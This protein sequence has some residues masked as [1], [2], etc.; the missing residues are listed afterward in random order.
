MRIKCELA[1][2]RL[3]VFANKISG[4]R[5]GRALCLLLVVIIVNIC[6]VSCGVKNGNDIELAS[7]DESGAEREGATSS[8][9]AVSTGNEI[10][11]LEVSSDGTAA[12]SGSS[13]AATSESGAAAGTAEPQPEIICVFV[14]GAVKNEGVYEL[15]AGS[16][17]YEAVEAA[18]GFSGEADTAYLNQAI[19]L[20]DSDMV[21][22]F[23]KEEIADP[24]SDASESPFVSDPD[25]LLKRAADNMT[26]NTSIG[27]A[28]A[29][30]SG[31]LPALVNINTATAEQL[32]SIPG[33]GETR[34]GTIIE[35]REANGNFAT[36]QDLMKV[37]GIKEGLFA[38]MKDHIT[39]GP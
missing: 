33:V 27:S 5:H 36:T 22:V 13:A 37:S 17:V 8:A 32:M 29:D 1:V 10:S 30:N 11:G 15:P 21:E 39:V 2:R 26:S 28:D 34:A 14:C 24:E 6:A 38:K 4:S 23:T 31:A 16:R 12:G 25:E 7:Y 9:P 35:Y 19:V 18:G 3:K 20:K